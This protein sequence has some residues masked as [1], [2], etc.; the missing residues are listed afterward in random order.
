MGNR[1]YLT[2]RVG[3]DG[4]VLL[5]LAAGGPAELRLVDSGALHR[6]VVAAYR[7]GR[8]AGVVPQLGH[9][10][11]PM[12]GRRVTGLDDALRRLVADDRL[13]QTS[14]AHWRITQMASAQARRHLAALS[15]EHRR[16]LG[17]LAASWRYLAERDAERRFPKERQSSS[18]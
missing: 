18:V 16:V 1:D 4:L 15:F 13:V 9:R 8:L 12:I 11:D 5:L 10:P 17:E 14:A 3:L 6:A 7:H 2:E